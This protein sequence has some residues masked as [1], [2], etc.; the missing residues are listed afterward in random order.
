MKNSVKKTR[1]DKVHPSPLKGGG[2]RVGVKERVGITKRL[3]KE[4]LDTA[5]PSP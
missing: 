5:N 3:R 4:F 2:R 1:D